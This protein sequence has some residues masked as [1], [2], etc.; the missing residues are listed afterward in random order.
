M[1]NT[2]KKVPVLKLH[3][4]HDDAIHEMSDGMA[5][6]RIWTL[7]TDGSETRELT[8]ANRQVL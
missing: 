1:T 8:V 2:D 7:L 4:T 3:E 6:F 5:I